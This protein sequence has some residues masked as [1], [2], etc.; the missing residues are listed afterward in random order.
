MLHVVDLGQDKCNL[1]VVLQFSGG[2]VK[3]VHLLPSN[4]LFFFKCKYVALYEKTDRCDKLIKTEMEALEVE[5]L[6]IRGYEKVFLK[7]DLVTRER[8]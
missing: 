6:N 4:Q 1:Q 2:R 5:G 7:I 8:C 3:A